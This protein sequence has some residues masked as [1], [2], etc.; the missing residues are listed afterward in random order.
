MLKWQSHKPR[1][2][3]IWSA[4]GRRGL[5][6]ELE[7][8][9]WD[10]GSSGPA[11]PEAMGLSVV[12]LLG[13]PRSVRVIVVG[14]FR[15]EQKRGRWEQGFQ[16]RPPYFPLGESALQDT[17]LGLLPAGPAHPGSNPKDCSRTQPVPLA[18]GGRVCAANLEGDP[19]TYAA[20]FT[21]RPHSMRFRRNSPPAVP[22]F[23]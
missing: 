1:V 12:I 3:L 21:L 5:T 16:S 20:G 18:S 22:M 6:C 17:T 19:R 13:W 7:A 4:D 15:P 2:D 11:G 14:T 8:S 9:A 23:P 10:V